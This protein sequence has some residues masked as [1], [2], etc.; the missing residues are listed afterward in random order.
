MILVDSSVWISHFRTDRSDLRADLEEGVVFSHEFVVGELACGTLARREDVLSAIAKL[1]SLPTAS[2]NEA[3]QLLETRRLWGRGLG[4]I[5]A[6]LL[7]S[8][9]LFGARLWTLDKRLA[10]AARRL[11]VAYR[12][13]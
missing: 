6:H 9:L 3:W 13:D 11:R 1:P 5:D 12:A 7:T 8:A 10:W 4:W 2:H